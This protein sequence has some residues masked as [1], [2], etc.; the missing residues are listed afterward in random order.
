M[1]VNNMIG[2]NIKQRQDFS[3]INK[4]REY[5]KLENDIKESDEKKEDD[6]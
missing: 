5:E 4:M 3:P 1:S 6:K 2:I